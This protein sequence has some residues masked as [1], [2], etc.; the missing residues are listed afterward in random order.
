MKD[1]EKKS[2]HFKEKLLEQKLLADRLTNDWF[3]KQGSGAPIRDK[4]GNIL[5]SRKKPANP[6]IM[7]YE[8]SGSPN[9]SSYPRPISGRQSLPMPE[10]NVLAPEENVINRTMNE[11]NFTTNNIGNNQI[12]ESNAGGLN[13]NLSFL[14]ENNNNFMDME[15]IAKKE[16]EKAVQQENYLLMEAKKKEKENERFLK[17]QEAELL[18]LKLQKEKE[19]IEA[20]R[21]F[22]FGH[23]PLESRNL[24]ET[25][26]DMSKLLN[27]TSRVN[28]ATNRTLREAT[29]TNFHATGKRPRTPVE[30]VEREIKELRQKEE[31]LKLQ[32][33]LLQELPLEVSK[34]VQSSIDVEMQK[35]KNELNFQQNLLGEQIMNLKGQ[36]LQSNDLRQESEK[37]IRR[38]HKEIQK[39]QLVDE[40]RQRE[41]YMALILKNRKPGIYHTI[42]ERLEEPET[43]DFRFPEKPKPYY[44]VYDPSIE[45][46]EFR[47]RDIHEIL[48]NRTEYLPISIHDERIAKGSHW[49]QSLE[50]YSYGQRME[51]ENTPNLPDDFA[52]LQGITQPRIVEDGDQV[53]YLDTYATNLKRLES[54]EDKHPRLELEKLDSHLFGLLS[55]VN[56]G[57]NTFDDLQIDK[58]RFLS[59]EMKGDET[60]IGDF[61]D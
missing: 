24:F 56:K 54:L 43:I 27:K 28:F 13:A 16:R 22:E 30:D 39:T 9:I 1:A 3:G 55:E 29:Q 37:E 61:Y 21:M 2:A 52:N 8:W 60:K 57:K 35:L 17:R 38:L 58:Y 4:F 11:N 42:T 19:E 46:L 14:L 34:T 53:Y 15:S 6:N 47:N 12:S 7:S 44:N 45:D 33:R 23:L 41:L 20:R 25:N 31:A 40:I 26:F 18:D 5:T 36:L 51:N 59:K 10:I 48:N 49:D 50:G 32:K